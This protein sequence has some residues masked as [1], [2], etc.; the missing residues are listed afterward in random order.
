MATRLSQQ[1][2]IDI[3]TVEDINIIKLRGEQGLAMYKEKLYLLLTSEVITVNAL[4]KL[5]WHTVPTIKKELGL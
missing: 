2:L 4:S 1:Q 5:S 3:L